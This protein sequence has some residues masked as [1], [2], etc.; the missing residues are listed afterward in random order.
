MKTDGFPR[1]LAIFSFAIF[2]WI[3]KLSSYLFIVMRSK[4]SSACAYPLTNTVDDQISLTN[5]SQFTNQLL[6]A[7]KSLENL[8]LED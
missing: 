5:F 2:S 6:F 7:L 1:F 3:L 4:I 8:F